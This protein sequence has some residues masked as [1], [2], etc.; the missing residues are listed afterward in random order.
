VPAT[1]PTLVQGS[2]MA[3][4]DRQV[5]GKYPGDAMT[6]A[7]LPYPPGAEVEIANIGAQPDGDAVTTSW[8]VAREAGVSQSTVSRALRGDPRVR[9]D[10]RRRVDEAARRLDYIPNSLA[11]SLASRST[12][13]V[14]VVVADLT[15]P[16]FP[17]LLT[18]ISDE[19]QLMGYRVVL[20]AER[21]DLPTGQEALTRLLDR[22]IDGVLV[23]T[24][25]LGSP[26]G[27]LFQQR[28]LPMVLLNRYID[29]LDVDRVVSDNRGAGLVGGRFLLEL[30][31]ERIGLIRGPA[32]TS[33]SRDR[34]AGFI[35][36]LETHGV[37]PDEALVR[38]GAY[39]HQ[40]GYQHTRELL[41]MPDPPTAIFCGNDVVA[42]GAM[43]AALSL[44]VQIPQDLSILGVDDIPMAAWE[45]FQLSTLRQPFGDMARA[46]ARML[47]ERIEHPATIGPGR[48]QLFATSLVKRATVDRPGR[49]P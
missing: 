44:G 8:T 35:D 45:V 11:S 28:G 1:D 6:S 40:S 15:N 48:E 26:F 30:G 46:A 9:E 7:G 37:R 13:T 21:T 24:A 19:L 5:P 49:R 20:F 18:P 3:V 42:F 39:S 36:A 34:M 27:A 29:G 2:A 25:T 32:N 38:L 16:F 43:D 12:R 22:S 10:T 17:T 41:R 31:H 33:T 4:A 47:V 14:A 23:T